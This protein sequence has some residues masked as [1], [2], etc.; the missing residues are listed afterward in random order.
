MKCAIREKMKTFKETYKNIDANNDKQEPFH[1]R[2]IYIYQVQIKQ[3][4]YV[5]K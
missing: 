4:Q 5:T 2:T 1:P 3:D